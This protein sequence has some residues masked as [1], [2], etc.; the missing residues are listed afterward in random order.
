MLQATHR[1]VY[2]LLS[3]FY[4]RPHKFKCYAFQ[5]QP[6]RIELN[7]QFDTALSGVR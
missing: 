1:K 6:S 7:G 5:S 3:T 4:S 2:E